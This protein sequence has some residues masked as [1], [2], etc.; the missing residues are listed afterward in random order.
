MSHDKLIT[1]ANQI[2]RFMESKPHAEG[3]TGLA[4]HINDFW[5]PRMRRQLFE[6]LDNGGDG[7][8]PLVLEAATQIRRPAAA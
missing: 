3:V 5:E 4:N 1:M 7:F 8:R 2:A 6:L